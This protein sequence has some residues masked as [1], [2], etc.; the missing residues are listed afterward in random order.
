[1]CGRPWKAGRL[2]VAALPNVMSLCTR[3]LVQA[4]YGAVRVRG[5]WADCLPPLL[6]IAAFRPRPL[7]CLR[8]Q[9]SH[10]AIP[11]TASFGG[12]PPP[13]PTGESVT[14]GQRAPD[15]RMLRI[16][17]AA[18]PGIVPMAVPSECARGRAVPNISVL[19]LG[20]GDCVSDCKAVREG[21][22][23]GWRGQIRAVQWGRCEGVDPV[24]PSQPNVRNEEGRASHQTTLFLVCHCRANLWTLMIGARERLVKINTQRNGW[25]G[26]GGRREAGRALTGKK[27]LFRNMVFSKMTACSS[28]VQPWL[29]AIGGWRLVDIAGWWLAAV[30]GNWQLVMGGWWRLAAVDSWRLAVGGW[31]LVVPWGGLGKKKSG[32]LRTALKGR[33]PG[34]TAAV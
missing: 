11:K 12:C 27:K 1:M 3:C 6:I 8:R 23:G 24:D 26:V 10:S 9:A 16:G 17:A 34:S 31:R 2:R 18:A 22:G 20:L 7:P 15:H 30:G 14:Q 4:T 33:A 28:Y 13:H 21:G 19:G 29:V 5:G 25:K 32:P